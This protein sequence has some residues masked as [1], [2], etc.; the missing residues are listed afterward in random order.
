MKED[1]IGWIPKTRLGKMVLK[2]EIK[3]ISEALR[4]GLS[5]REPEIVDYL[6]P[7]LEDEVLDVN[8]VQRMTDSGRRVNFVITTVIGNGDGFVG[9]GRARGK[10]VGPSIRKSIEN[11]KKNLIE[12]KRGC[13]SW[14]CGCGTPH[15]LP[16]KVAGKSGSVEVTL[17]PAPRGVTLAVGDVSKHVLRVAGIKDAWG[18][19]KGHT[20]TT[21]NYALAT[22]NALIETSA[23]KVTDEQKNRLRI[24]SG[25]MPVVEPEI[26]VG[27]EE[28]A[29]G[30]AETAE[31]P[32]ETAEEAKPAIPPTTPD[33][34]EPKKEAPKPAVK[35]AERPVDKKVEKP[36]EKEEK[37]AV[38]KEAPK[39]EKEKAK[40]EKAEVKEKK[41]E[42]EVKDEPPTEKE[43]E[44]KPAEEKETSP[45]K[46][47]SGDEEK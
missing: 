26:P 2:G 47:K 14:E 34:E 15:S 40:D 5:L 12:I 37:P 22:F 23:L 39:A 27:E 44:E 32:A 4:S 1:D 41:E 31:A 25:S 30:A 20:K 8:M 29:E 19:T 11:A 6:L 18:F 45:E 36:P 13:G 46:E 33:K 3:T 7:S 21:V 17:K 35:P 42:P 9:L 10:E 28:E 24:L 38:K 16:F 43:K